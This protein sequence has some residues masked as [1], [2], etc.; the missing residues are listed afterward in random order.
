MELISEV[1]I[2]RGHVKSVLCSIKNV[3]KKLDRLES[4]NSIDLMLKILSFI[5]VWEVNTKT[6]GETLISVVAF[7]IIA[8]YH[9]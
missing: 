9:H 4:Q 2:M 6:G 8:K 1:T 7:S 3:S 5:L